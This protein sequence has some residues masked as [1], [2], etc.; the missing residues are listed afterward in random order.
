MNSDGT[1]SVDVSNNS[2][3]DTR[4]SLS[5]DGTKIVFQSLRNG[6]NWDIYTMNADGTN[7]TQLTFNGDLDDAPEWSPDGSKIAFRRYYG[8]QGD[9]WV[10]NADGS[11]QVAVTNGTE[12]DDRPAWSPDGTKLAFA[13]WNRNGD[14]D[15]E[16]YVMN[17]DG[18]NQVNLTN[19]PVNDDFLPDWQ[20]LPNQQQQ[21]VFSGFFQPIDM[22]QTNAAKAGKTIPV[23]WR[24]LDAQGNPVSDPQSFVSLTSTATP[25]SCGGTA[26]WVETYSGSSG[27]QYLGNGYWQYNW[28][29]PVTYAGQCRDMH[30]NLNDNTVKVASFIFK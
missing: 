14:T 18:T 11:N 24:L 23:K 3:K 22:N 9:I 27:L 21:Y 28:K 13:S 15:P 20:P 29:T 4:G 1:N 17:A 30:L 10:M 25:N 7:V 19:N 26:D 2:Y 8:N 5:P 16:I 12:D 6:Q